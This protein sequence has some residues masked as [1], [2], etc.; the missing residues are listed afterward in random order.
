MPLVDII[1]YPYELNLLIEAAKAQVNL[2]EGSKLDLRPGEHCQFCPASTICK[3]REQAFLDAAGRDMAGANL[4][5]FAE[6]NPTFIGG[7]QLDFAWVARTIAAYEQLGGWINDLRTALDEHLLA[8]GE[9]PG[10]KVV[11][12]IARRKW[13]AADADVATWL[14]LNYGVPEAESCPPKLV[15]ITDAKKLLKDY[16]P[17]GK[18]DEA[19]R[20]L[21][22]NFTIKESSGLTTAPESDKRP[23]VQP[24]AAEFGSVMVG[25][26]EGAD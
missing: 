22:L 12:K 21:T 7:D 3:A 23:A 26:L 10:W 6:T 18:F 11:E 14:E 15:T 5:V 24:V 9:V 2:P 4:E 13:M 16:V 19:E 1:E 17:K 25:S 8:G 20:A